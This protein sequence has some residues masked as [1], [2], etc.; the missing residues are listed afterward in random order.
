MVHNRS[1]SEDAYAVCKRDSIYLKITWLAYIILLTV[2][3]LLTVDRNRNFC[4]CQR[5]TGLGGKRE[6]ITVRECPIVQSGARFSCII[7]QLE[8]VRCARFGENGVAKRYRYNVLRGR[9]KKKKVHE[10][11]KDQSKFPSIIT[12]PKYAQ[13]M[14]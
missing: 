4:D 6:F 3:I 10:A 8:L 7:R 9:C 1:C 14:L 5:S 12:N 13:V 11:E 2:L